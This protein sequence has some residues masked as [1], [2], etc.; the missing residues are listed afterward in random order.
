[1]G[2]CTV[3]DYV[4][5]PGRSIVD[6]CTLRVEKNHHGTPATPRLPSNPSTTNAQ[7][8]LYKSRRHVVVSTRSSGS[9]VELANLV[10]RTK[11]TNASNECSSIAWTGSLQPSSDSRLVIASVGNAASCDEIAAADP[12]AG[13]IADE[14]P[15]EGAGELGPAWIPLSGRVGRSERCFQERSPQSAGPQ[16]AAE[17][18]EEEEEVLDVSRP[19][20]SGSAQAAERPV[21]PHKRSPGSAGPQ[22]AA[23]EE[24]SLDV[25]RPRT[26]GFA[27][28]AERPAPSP[29]SVCGAEAR[30]AAPSAVRAEPSGACGRAAPRPRAGAPCG[31]PCAQAG[32]A[33]AAHREALVPA[34]APTP[35]S[36][37]ACL[38]D[39]IGMGSGT[40]VVP[41]GVETCWE[42]VR[43]ST[44]I[45]VG[46][47][48]ALVAVAEVIFQVLSEAIRGEEPIEVTLA[49]GT[50]SQ[51][52][53]A[54]IPE[55]EES[56]DEFEEINM[57]TRQTWC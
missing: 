54:S 21:P 34:S 27:P 9:A 8:S 28:A 7:V 14:L 50:P 13:P 44:R 29:P 10:H 53:L 56:D 45:V 41:V 1:M 23:E 16:G 18:E 17:E 38:S 4:A 24:E 42:G 39:C 20:T 32:R 25:S 47:V 22:G 35:S 48:F 37:S 57:K 5:C 55:E 6:S 11:A 12:R 26:S 33:G 52:S 43:I 36:S 51:K 31:G 19:G 3:S 49:R 46:S 30:G 2:Q 15:C 40:K